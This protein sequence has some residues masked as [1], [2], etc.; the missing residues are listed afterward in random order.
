MYIK[1]NKGNKIITINNNKTF[2]MIMKMKIIIFNNFCDN[3]YMKWTL[4]TFTIINRIFI[5]ENLDMLF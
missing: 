1:I 4:P 2:I 5:Q 3:L